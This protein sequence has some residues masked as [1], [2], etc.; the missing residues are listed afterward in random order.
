MAN[1]LRQHNIFLY[2]KNKIGSIPTYDTHNIAVPYRG[3]FT[4]TIF[5][6]PSNAGTFSV[7]RTNQN[8]VLV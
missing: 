7:H 1:S 6:V 3:L 4:D 5:L 8:E 2:S